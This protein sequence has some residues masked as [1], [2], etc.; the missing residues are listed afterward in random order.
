[1]GQQARS[2]D[3]LVDHLR[4]HRG[5][6]RCFATVADPLATDMALHGEHARCVIELLADI[7]TD[8]FERAATG[9]LRVVRLVMDQRAGKLRRQ[10]ATFGFLLFLG[11]CRS[12]L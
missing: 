4:R 11:G 10:G 6:D 8:A 1:M 5:L 12:H 2:R 3:A 9:T 7:F